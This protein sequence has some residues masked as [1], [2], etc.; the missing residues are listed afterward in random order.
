MRSLN[1]KSF[2]RTLLQIH[3][4]MAKA[5]S[6][7][8]ALT[9]LVNYTVSTINC[10]RGTIF[11]IDK[12]THELYSYIALGDLHHEIRVLDDKGVVGWSFTN[13]QAVCIKDA[14]QDE[15]F[16]QEIDQVTG[17]TTKSILCVPIKDINHQLIGVAQMLNKVDGE[18][19]E[20]DIEQVRDLT[21][22]AS[23]A[24]QNRLVITSME[25]S[26]NKELEFLE[27]MSQVSAEIQLSPLLEKIIATVTRMLDAER[28]TLFIN[29]TKTNELFTEVG[30]GL[31]K[32]KI[33]FPNHLG[34]AGAVFT[35]DKI[36]NIQHAYADLRF[37]PTFDKTT[38]YFTRTILAVPV[39]NK[40]GK[41]IGVTQVLNK[42]HG[43]F[44]S[45]D[46][47]QL[48]AINTQISFALE[49]AKLFDDVQDLKNYNESVLESMSNGVLTVDEANNII[50]CNNSVL[51]IFGLTN[52][53]EIINQTCENL[54]TG[55]NAWL[56]E[57]VK[58]INAQTASSEQEIIMDTELKFGEKKIS[59]N[60]TILP[61][62]STKN[63]RLG[64]MILIE[65]ISDEKRMKSTMS[66]YMSPDVAEKLMQ[67]GESS[68]GGSSSVASV[69]FSDLRNFTTLTE[70]LGAEGTVTLL[71]D[72]FTLMV[73]CIQNEGGMLDKFIG[74]AIMAVFGIPFAHEDDPDRSVRAGIA[75]MKALKVFNKEREKKNLPPIDHGLGINTDMIVSG[76][77][78]SEKR[79]DYTVIG[80]GVNLAS[81]IES[82]C[83]QYG[84]HILISEF[85]FKSLKATYR[86]RQ[87]DKVI[88]KGKN[89]PVAIYEVI[90][91]YDA[92]TFPNQIEVLSHFNDG[93]EYYNLA[94]WDKSI[95]CFEKALKLHPGDKPSTVYVERCQH[96]RQ[97]TPGADWNGVW[98]MKTK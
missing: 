72:Y 46:E 30:E 26:H 5:T 45:N 50:T 76:N 78:G 34:I 21:R 73:D 33:R 53:S 70:A 37:N 67:S 3:D 7:H 41:V 81:R 68:L 44:T 96:L 20:T 75:M 66:R 25:N 51:R 12:S 47:S 11:L 15:R 31:G 18:F 94:Q 23:M 98:V 79:M 97:N 84:A 29:D 61:L 27:A 69:L 58:K 32:T 39:K 36:I 54:F 17:F 14:Y 8:E 83:K 93:I 43:V 22:Q 95:V 56:S 80:D 87:L 57:K 74:D 62:F 49:N 9:M 28:S 90:D 65:D 24:I 82:L 63:K 52:V 71:N 86:T 1:T 60:V 92:E 4:D 40:A 35:S 59:S 2:Y 77:I 85:T 89:V 88:V 13:D 55:A 42:K 48:I 64:S 38:G 91:F 10:E 16:N 19:T 6:L